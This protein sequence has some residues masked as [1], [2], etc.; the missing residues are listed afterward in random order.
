MLKGHTPA[1][2]RIVQRDFE[3]LCGMWCT[4]VEIADFF[5]VDE[6]TLNTWCKK[7]YGTTFSET[8]KKKSSKG[9]ISLRRAQLKTAVEKLNP[10]MMIW[11]G[12][13]YLGQR[14]IVETQSRDLD[15]LDEILKGIE[16]EANN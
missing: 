11:L 15:K 13:Q 10:T 7:T 14:D 1:Q 8:Y 2:D 4:E 16:N 6:D 5:D 12:R 3:N 9:N